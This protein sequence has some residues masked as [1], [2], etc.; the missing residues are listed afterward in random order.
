MLVVHLMSAGR[1]RYLRPARRGRRRRRSA[2]RFEDGAEL[3]LTE[4]GKKKRAGVW[5]FT[6]EALD[7]RA[8]APRPGGARARRAS[9]S[10]RS[11]APRRTVSIRCSATSARSPASAAPGRTRS[12][13]PRTSRRTRCRRSSTDEEVERLATAIDAELERGLALRLEGADNAHTYRVHNRLGEPCPE[14]ATPIAQVD[15]EE[16]TIYYCPTC[17]TGGRVLKDRRLSRLLK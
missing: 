8:R 7:E 1:L 4:A 9:G 14:C 15:F 5:L 16:H 13:A 17:Q 6:P 12:S 11:C 3:V 10:P 2:L